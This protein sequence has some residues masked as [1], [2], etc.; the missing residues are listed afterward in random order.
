MDEQIS[1]DWIRLG[2][3]PDA[4]FAALRERVTA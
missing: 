2:G 1:T 4:Y 3:G